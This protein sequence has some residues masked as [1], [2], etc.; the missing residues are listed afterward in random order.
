VEPSGEPPRPAEA[1]FE[2]AQSEPSPTWAELTALPKVNRGLPRISPVN[3]V[4]IVGAVA[5]LAFLGSIFFTFSSEVGQ[6]MFTTTDP[7]GGNSCVVTS[8]V[9]SINRGEHVWL[10]AVFKEPIGHD[11]LTLE[12]RQNGVY[13]GAY[14][15]P[16]E[17]TEGGSCTWSEDLAYYPPGTWKF[18]FLR[19]GQFEEEGSI[20]IK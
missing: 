7:N 6:V 13:K 19:N 9:T 4:F 2:V 1:G 18:T 3:L 11:Q 20:T 16:V 8:R 5:V 10:V 14:N 12:Y 15:W 17:D